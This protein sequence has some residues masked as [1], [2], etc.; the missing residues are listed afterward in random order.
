ME[1]KEFAKQLELRTK[2][3]A[4]R[5]IELLSTLTSSI[6]TKVVRNQMTKSGTSIGAN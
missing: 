6:E 4:I 2:Q 1:N 3:F 5:I